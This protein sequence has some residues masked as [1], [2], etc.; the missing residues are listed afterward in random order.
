VAAK[1]C[2]ADIGHK[3]E[4]GGVQLNITSSDELSAAIASIITSVE[5]HA[6][7]ARLDGILIESMISNAIVELMVSL[8]RDPQFGLVLTMASGGVMTEIL[9]D[10]TTLLVPADDMS[11]QAALDG[12]RMARLFD[13]FRGGPAASRQ[14]ILDQIQTLV[15][16]MQARSDIIEI[17]INPVM[18][19]TD[20]AICADALITVIDQDDQPAS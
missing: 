17:E 18:V 3:T 11:V 6:P 2:S 9:Q 12:L 8:R 20:S 19:S 1:I 16:L 14:A 10:A 5:T 7:N 13:G 15:R 4:I